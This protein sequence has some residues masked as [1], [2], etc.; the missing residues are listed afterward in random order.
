MVVHSI[1]CN[2]LCAY[3]FLVPEPSALVWFSILKCDTE[4]DIINN[5]IFCFDIWPVSIIYAASSYRR[6][7]W[8]SSTVFRV[9][10]VNWEGLY[11]AK[12]SLS[13][14]LCTIFLILFITFQVSKYF[15]RHSEPCTISNPS[16]DIK[17]FGRPK[18]NLN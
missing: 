10:V 17:M 18:W 13:V 6:F 7:G 2:I 3:I 9:L 15:H 8:I 12:L 14:P 1:F 11:V 4:D 16:L 5:N